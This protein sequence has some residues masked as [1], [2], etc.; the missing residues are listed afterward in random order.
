MKIRKVYGSFKEKYDE[1]SL[2]YG[3]IF[4]TYQWLKMFDNLLIYGIFDEG[5][6]L[7]GGFYLYKEKK[8]GLI[9]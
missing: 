4:N 8:F 6:N 5:D 7:I 3:S 9:I 1:L 2:S